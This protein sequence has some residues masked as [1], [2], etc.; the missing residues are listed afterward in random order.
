MGIPF[1]VIE[2]DKPRK[3]R[4]GL[5]GLT[6][7]EE[8]TGKT[9]TEI[10]EEMSMNDIAKVLYAGLSWDDKELTPEKVIELVDDYA[11]DL[12]YVIKKLTEAISNAVGKPEAQAAK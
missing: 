2:L 1:E 3:I 7:A 12:G 8:M 11:D 5:A 10:C 6:L 4:F 9:I